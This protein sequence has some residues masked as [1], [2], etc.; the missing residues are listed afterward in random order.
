[1]IFWFL[2]EALTLFSRLTLLPALQLI[3]KATSA[4][5]SKF[6]FSSNLLSSLPPEE[7]GRRKSK[8]HVHMIPF[9][10]I[11]LLQKV[12]KIDVLRVRINPDDTGEYA[13]RP[14]GALC[15]SLRAV[16]A[17]RVLLYPS[18]WV[19]TRPASVRRRRVPKQDMAHIVTHPSC[20]G[21]NQ[22]PTKDVKINYGISNCALWHR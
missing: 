20:S 15:D 14:W 4:S 2:S 8:A 21:Q 22:G 11:I 3:S 9:L 5:D 16:R 12:V 17:V 13:R 18:Y 10:G 6:F 7:A 19:P 1:M